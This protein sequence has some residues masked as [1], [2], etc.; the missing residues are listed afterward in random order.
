M[1]MESRGRF[2]KI[3]ELVFH[4]GFFFLHDSADTQIIKELT[5]ALAK[6]YY[7]VAFGILYY[8][9]EKHLQYLT[10]T[11]YNCL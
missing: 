1:Y 6:C 10:P 8:S 11:T 7:T 4:Y 2:Q 9:L 3:K 5:S